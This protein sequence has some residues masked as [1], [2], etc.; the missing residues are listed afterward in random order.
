MSRLPRLLLPALVCFLSAAAHPLSPQAADPPDKAAQSAAAGNSLEL[1]REVYNF[2]CYFCHGYSGDAQTLAARF[3]Q[4]PP[5]DFTAVQSQLLD[6]DIMLTAVRDGRAGTAMKPFRDVLDPAQLEAVVDYVRSAFMARRDPNT[7]YH[8]RENG[9]PEH[10]RFRAAFPFATGEI[11]LDTPPQTL[12]ETAIA[13]RRLYL[14]SCISCHDRSR[15]REQAVRWE[16]VAL[17]YPRPGFAPGDSLLPPDAVSGATPFARHELPPALS[18]LTQRERLGEQLFQ[19]NCAF[20]HAADGT[21]RNWI[22]TF[23]Q[24]PP[25][26]LTDPQFMRGMTSQRLRQ[27][28]RDGLP[29]TSMPA[30]KHVLDMPQ[31]DAVIAYVNRAF[32]P[33][34]DTDD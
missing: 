32:H 33:L 2:R 15:V 5:R 18:D 6:R 22:G 3:L 30:W 29:G 7:R 19:D 25:R 16:P 26:D 9:W 20:C 8:T 12:S 4:P 23:L 34:S 31:I 14:K 1:G 17:S 13:G 27:V 21:G 28:I 10:E 24:P 11:P